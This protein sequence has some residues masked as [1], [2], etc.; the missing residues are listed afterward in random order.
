M[1]VGFPIANHKRIHK[2]IMDLIPID[3]KHSLRTENSQKSLLKTFHY[4]NKDTRKVKDFQK[5]FNKEICFTNLIVLNT[6]IF[7][8]S[9]HGKISLK[10]HLHI[11]LRNILMNIYFLSGIKLSIFLSPKTLQ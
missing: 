2:R 9:F 6:T 1:I 7:S 11:G 5:L 3:W 8:C 4:N 10:E